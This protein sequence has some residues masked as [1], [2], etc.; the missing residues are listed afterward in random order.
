MSDNLGDVK[1]IKLLE[2]IFI[3]IG[4]NKV[5]LKDLEDP[6]EHFTMLFNK[7]GIFDAHKTKE[8]IK[9]EYESLLKV[10]LAGM[11]GQILNPDEFE[12]LVAAEILSQVKKITF[13]EPEYSKFLVIDTQA[14]KDLFSYA[15]M[16]K[17]KAVLTEESIM[18]SNFMNAV[19]TWNEA[20][21]KIKNNAIVLTED[22]NLAG[23]LF[24]ENDALF[25]SFEAFKNT[26]IWK[27]VNQMA[28]MTKNASEDKS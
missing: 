20:K 1:R 5:M 2:K 28:D 14:G 4:E 19:A 18:K 27:F 26:T 23:W 6:N 11:L 15:T 24:N 22:G 17:R 12:K 7:A 21:S 16:E 3:W 8:G 13:D 9:K 10:D 25:V